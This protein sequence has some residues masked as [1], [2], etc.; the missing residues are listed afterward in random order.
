MRVLAREPARE[1]ERDLLQQPP[2]ELQGEPRALFFGFQEQTPLAPALGQG[3][4]QPLKVQ[5]GFSRA[6]AAQTHART[7]ATG[8]EQL[9]KVRCR[10]LQGPQVFEL[11]EGALQRFIHALFHALF[12]ASFA[13]ERLHLGR[14]RPDVRADLGEPHVQRLLLRVRL[15]KQ[16]VHA[17]VQECSAHHGPAALDDGADARPRL[18]REDLERAARGALEQSQRRRGE[19]HKG[20]RK[21]HH[22]RVRFHDG[23]HVEPRS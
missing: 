12:E 1:A 15:D 23:G 18:E 4:L 21:E 5:R 19:P 7:A 9:Q 2:F 3:A 16:R 10:E 6:L 13:H 22:E 20:Q 17:V 11:R 8:H 14:E